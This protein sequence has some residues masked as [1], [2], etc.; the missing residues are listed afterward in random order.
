MTGRRRPAE[1]GGPGRYRG[2]AVCE[3]LMV[4]WP[5]P[6]TLDRILPWASEVERL[7]V[8]GFGWGVAWREGGRIRRYRHPTALAADPDGRG[9]LARVR[10]DRALVHLRRPARLSTVGVADTQPF[11]AGGAFA[12]CHNG[13]FRRHEEHR[14]RLGHLLEGRADSEVGFRVFEELLASGDGP[15]GALARTHELLGG[16]ANLGYL[17]ADGTLAV[18]AGFE[19]NPVWSFTVE[20]ARAAATALH[21]DDASL[22][23]LVFPGARDREPVRGART[24]TPAPPGA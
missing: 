12:F 9:L 20:G 21:S 5:E 2:G 8:A 6:V 3:I 22:F 17:G 15:E 14:A 11:L 24:I 7:G 1:D 4:A 16:S 13:T 19:T 23:D 18:Y 10:S